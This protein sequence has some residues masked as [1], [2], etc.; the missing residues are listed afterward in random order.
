MAV[1]YSFTEPLDYL[2]NQ[3]QTGWGSRFC[4]IGIFAMPRISTTSC[5][6]IV[7]TICR[8]SPI[9]DSSIWMTRDD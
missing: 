3:N 5:S 9:E 1:Q 7:K 8:T 2:L 4:I 6:C